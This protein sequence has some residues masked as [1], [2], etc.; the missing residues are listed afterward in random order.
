M[1]SRCLLLGTSVVVLAVTVT[2]LLA[3]G[4]AV[5]AVGGSCATGGPYAIVAPCPEHSTALLLVGMFGSVAAALVGT[6]LAVGLGA[7]NLLV[8]YVVA[9]FGG[10][11]AEFL[12]S[13]IRDGSGVDV[14]VGVLLAVLFVLPGLYVLSPWQRVYRRQP[15]PGAPL[16]RGAWWLVYLV[17]AALGA[18]AGSW[19]ADRWL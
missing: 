8:P 3:A 2:W 6:V 19:T 17:L 15:V 16:S 18:L 11:S 10:M 4:R 5:S 12:V 9:T 1:R 7:P 13:G 14:A